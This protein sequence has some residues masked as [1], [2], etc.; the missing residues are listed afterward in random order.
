MAKVGIGT[1]TPSYNLDLKSSSIDLPSSI[2]MANSDFSKYLRLSSGND[3][4]DPAIYFSGGEALRFMNYDGGYS[5]LMR[6]TGDGKVGIGT[7]APSYDLDII[8]S[9]TDIHSRIRITNSDNSKQLLLSSGSDLHDSH[10]SFTGGD[11]M[12]F[13]HYDGGYNELMRITSDG[14]LDVLGDIQ[15]GNSS[16]PNPSA[17]TI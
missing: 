14:K 17:G 13:M 9:S 6:I 1:T 7:T 12:R 4:Y 8:S 11:A 10:I 3:T 2:R 15:V 5:E 16:D